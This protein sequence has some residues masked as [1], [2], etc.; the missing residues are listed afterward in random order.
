MMTQCFF[1]AI[2]FFIIQVAAL[3]SV[4]QTGNKTV[5]TDSVKKTITVIKRKA[6]GTG[7][8]YSGYG[9]KWTKETKTVYDFDRK[10]ISRSIS[11][12][13]HIGPDTTPVKSKTIQYEN[14]KKVAKGIK[15]GNQNRKVK[16]KKN[17][18]I[19]L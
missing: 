4:A 14:G 13:K 8:G 1:S 12:A 15:N 2:L 7:Q 11:S 10:K 9:P 19:F 6:R 18:L 16:E 3:P 17:T 5:E